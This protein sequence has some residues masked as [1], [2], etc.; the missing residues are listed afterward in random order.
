MSTTEIGKRN[1]S[2]SSD[3]KQTYEETVNFAWF[4]RDLFELDTGDRFEANMEAHFYAK[5]ILE[6]L[7][8]EAPY[9]TDGEDEH[10]S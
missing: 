4:I 3:K 10:E 7:G 1:G 9:Y 2:V 6:H 5:R 8:V